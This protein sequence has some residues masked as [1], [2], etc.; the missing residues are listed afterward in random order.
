MAPQELLMIELSTAILETT[1]S[2]PLLKLILAR[3]ERVIVATEL[4]PQIKI[5]M[6]RNHGMNP[7]LVVLISVPLLTILD[8]GHLNQ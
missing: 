8:L 6:N 5:M 2:P 4:A 3:T 7:A 1:A